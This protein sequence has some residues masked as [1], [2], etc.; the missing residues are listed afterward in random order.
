MLN[1]SVER[2]M[3]R[4]DF[5]GLVVP[6]AVCIR[7]GCITWNRYV[8]HIRALNLCGQPIRVQ[9]NW[10]EYLSS[11]NFRSPKCFGGSTL[12]FAA[13][14]QGNAPTYDQIRGENKKVRLYTFALADVGKKTRLYGRD[15]NGQPLQEKDSNGD[16]VQGITLTAAIPFVSTTQDIQAI[17]RVQRE[18]TQLHQMLY[19]YDTVNDTLRDLAD[20]YPGE[21]DP[22]YSR[23]K[24]VGRCCQNSCNGLTSI[25]A[26]VKLQ[27]LPVVGDDDLVMISNV[28]ALKFMFKAIRSEEQ[29]DINAGFQWET[30]AIKELNAELNDANPP[31]TTPVAY[32]PFAG[33]SFPQQS[34]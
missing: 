12:K 25:V 3:H 8:G 16:W 13:M 1:E 19:E 17:D 31:Q 5:Q 29:G 14:E 18:V 2:L 9:N 34:I 11:P 23:S 20:Y 27:F 7:D 32:E 10:F 4:G 6:M 15:S 33:R 21:T 30:K 24:L 28:P 26:M 22:W